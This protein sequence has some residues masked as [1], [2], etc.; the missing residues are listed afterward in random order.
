MSIPCTAVVTGQHRPGSAAERNCPVHGMKSVQTVAAPVVPAFPSTSTSSPTVIRRSDGS[1]ASEVWRDEDG[2]LHREDGPAYIQR[3]A[4]GVVTR[5]VWH[6][7]GRTHRVDG[8]AVI[9]RDPCGVVTLE[10]WWADGRN[11][12]VD[13]PATIR[14]LLDGTIDYEGFRLR[15]R[16]AD[17]HEVF[18]EFLGERASGLSEYGLRE[19]ASNTPYQ[20]WRDITDDQIAVMRL[21][22]PNFADGSLPTIRS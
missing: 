3:D 12:R 7:D 9:V 4:N 20:Q 13:G 2:R 6:V 18:A 14:Y 11:H 22:Y 10:Q 21:L 16:L 17:A 15:G 8:P 5:E 1:V 19:L